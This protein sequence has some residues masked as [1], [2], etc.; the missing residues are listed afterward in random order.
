M[1]II[2][3]ER[4]QHRRYRLEN[5]VS[6]SSHGIFQLTDLSRGGFCFR[7]PP[8]TP[9]TDVWVTD[10]LT[11]AFSLEG[12]SAKLAWVSV[13]ENGK[14]GYLRTMGGAKFT[15]LDKKQDSLLEQLIETI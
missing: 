14:R 2:P 15:R 6:I 4:R 9:I 1:L 5:S 3:E 7:C 12:F 11:S 10:I 8:Y 13:T